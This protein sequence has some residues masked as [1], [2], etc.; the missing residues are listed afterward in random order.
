MNLLIYLVY[1]KDKSFDMQSLKAFKSLEAY[2]FFYIYSF[3][4][5]FID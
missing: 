4:N 5:N 1:G 2:K 3:C